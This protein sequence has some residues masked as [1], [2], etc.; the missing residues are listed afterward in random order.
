MLGMSVSAQS[1]REWETYLRDVVT[2]EDV[3][4][5]AWEEMY[6]QLCELDQHPI[7]LNQASREQLEQLPFLS[8]QQVEDIMAY[9]YQYGPMKSSA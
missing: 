3:G 2:V 1:E 6:E 4:T 5:A 9:L 8:A 7:N